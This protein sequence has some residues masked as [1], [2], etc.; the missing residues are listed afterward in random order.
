MK[1]KRTKKVYKSKG[2]KSSRN[3]PDEPQIDI[4]PDGSY[5]CGGV[6]RQKCGGGFR[7]LK[8]RFNYHGG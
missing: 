8:T 3:S 7:V 4:H 2:Y 1:I 5:S 6:L